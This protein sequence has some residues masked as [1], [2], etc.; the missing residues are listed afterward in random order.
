[1]ICSNGSAPLYKMAAMP[2]YGKNT[3][4]VQCRKKRVTFVGSIVV[5]IKYLLLQNQENLSI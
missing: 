1:M 5:P 4:C 3:Y 2:M